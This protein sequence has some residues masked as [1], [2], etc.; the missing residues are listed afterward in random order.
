MLFTQQAKIKMFKPWEMTRHK[1]SLKN[2]SDKDVEDMMLHDILLAN[3]KWAVASKTMLSS[4]KNWVM[5]HVGYMIMKASVDPYPT[6]KA[7]IKRKDNTI[8]NSLSRMNEADAGACI[9][10]L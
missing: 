9:C 3:L 8:C 6:N 10:I 7:Y 2:Y 1:Y 5:K 4:D